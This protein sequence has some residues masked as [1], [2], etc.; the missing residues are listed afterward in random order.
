MGKSRIQNPEAHGT[1]EEVK[2]E[3]EEVR[4]GGL[5]VCGQMRHVHEYPESRIQDRHRRR[6][7]SGSL[8]IMSSHVELI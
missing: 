6:Y 2:E 7:H 3:E 4:G 8:E 5:N 1:M